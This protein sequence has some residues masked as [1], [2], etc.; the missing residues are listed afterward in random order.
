MEKYKAIQDIIHVCDICGKVDVLNYCEKCQSHF[1]DTCADQHDCK[2]DQG[3]V[4][5]IRQRLTL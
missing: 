4:N 5:T 1:C 2:K 3:F